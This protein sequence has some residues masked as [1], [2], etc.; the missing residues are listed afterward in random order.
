MDDWSPIGEHRFRQQGEVLCFVPHGVLSPAQAEVWLAALVRH[1]QQHRNGFLLID[2]RV[3]RPPGAEVRRLVLSA[4]REF[5][6]RP[7]L[8]IFGA[9]V[10]TR[11]VSRLVLAAARQLHQIHLEL[12]HCSSAADAWACVDQMREVSIESKPRL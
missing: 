7:R 1:F 4:L 8:I 12:T 5:Q 10:V 2:A 3:L 11:A 6:L 9:N